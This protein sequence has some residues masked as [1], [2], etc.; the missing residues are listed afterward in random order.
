M[1]RL[2][3][4]V[5]L[6]CS[7]LIS[8]D[9]YA[10]MNEYNYKRELSGVKDQWHRLEISDDLFEKTSTS[11]A[12][13][14]IYGITA[15][16]D[17]VIAPYVLDRKENVWSTKN[18]NF[19]LI[20]QS[21]KGSDFY[22]TYEVPTAEAINQIDLDFSI[23]NFDWRVQLAGSQ[24][25]QE[26]FTILEDYRILSIKNSNTDY[27]YTKLIF[28]NA[29]YQFFRL[30]ITS[31]KNP[32]LQKASLTMQENIAGDFKNY[33]PKDTEIEEKIKQKNTVI[34]LDFGKRIPISSLK[35]NVENDI[36]Y[37]RS[38]SIQYVKDS[39]KTDKGWRYNYSTLAS[40][41]LTSLE[42]NEFY[43]NS[44]LLQKVKIIIR[45]QDNQALK[46]GAISAKGPVYELAARFT[47]E[48]RY[49]LV[50]GNEKARKPSYDISRFKDNIPENMSDLL[51]GEE[52][53]IDKVNEEKDQALFSNP[54]WL[55]LIMG[56]II[57][58][59][60]WFTLKMM[61]EKK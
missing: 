53:P 27:Q 26:W 22:Y 44:T 42:E 57:L 41:T 43:F 58:L 25:Q 39:V 5:F 38:T 56:L 60:G 45:N 30:K 55:Y 18:V 52:L 34:N 12:D 49:Y 29:K 8:F 28:P 35:L 51:L 40:G 13:I 2:L 36:D 46:I 17:T 7:I 59:L 14:R 9:A 11:L 37:Y 54:I 33:L 47:E 21:K 31:D 23:L 32:D 3:N 24:N 6:L 16:N 4:L 50:Y 20:N 15:Q 1:K 48:G 10:Q 61:N 19:N